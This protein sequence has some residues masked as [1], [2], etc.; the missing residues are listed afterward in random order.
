MKSIKR[1]T[2]VLSALVIGMC[3]LA[4]SPVI[5]KAEPLPSV[6]IYA[7]TTNSYDVQA[8]TVVVDRESNY[9]AYVGSDLIKEG[10]IP[11][12]G[13]YLEF[14][15]SST[16]RLEVYT[17]YD[18]NDDGVMDT[19]KP[20][21]GYSAR[22]YYLTVS[23]VEDDGSVLFS[24]QLLMDANNYPEYVYNAPA[25]VDAGS[26]VYTTSQSSVLIQYGSDD[27]TI[28][29][30][31]GSREA[32]HFSITYV[33]ENDNVIY[34]ETDPEETTLEY[35]QVKHID[36][37]ETF[38][39]NGQEYQLISTVRSY[40]VTYDNA[41]SAYVFEYAPV[42]AAPE[43]PYEITI[44]LVDADNNNALLYSIRQTV[45][46]G[47]SVRVELPNTYEVNFKQYVLEDGV[48]N[49]IERDF[50]STAPVK[51]DIP[52]RVA[53]ESVPYD[54]SINFIDYNNQDSILTTVSG[55]VT[56]DGAPFVYDLS[57]NNTYTDE[58]GT[59]YQLMAGQGNENGQI[60]HTYGSATRVYNIYYT[61]Q[62]VAD[63]QPY[64]VTMRYISV[65]DNSVLE[66][67]EQEVEY[68]SSVE[69]EAAP[70]NLTIDGTEYTRL[71]GQEDGV[72]HDYNVN[73]TDYAVYYIE[74]DAL[75]AEEVEPEVVTQVVTQYVTEEG[76][77]VENED[78]TAVPE[79]V[80]VT[81]VTGGDDEGTAYNEAGQE[82][83][84][85]EGNIEVVEP[86]EEVEAIPDEETPLG[87]Q[88]LEEDADTETADSEA[89]DNLE[90]IEDEETPLANQD[91]EESSAISPI[92]IVVII[93]A[94]AVVAVLVVISVKRKAN[95]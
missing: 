76:T 93:A 81:V 28:P 23:G 57:S 39:Y 52:Y 13:G 85:N 78:G 59:E 24:E 25:T 9:E 86:E 38:N 63:P 61:A 83:E 73:R 10:T 90:A 77:V 72:S 8:F 4:A 32:R 45:D 80:P 22:S 51:Y 42:I 43:E 17:P 67:Q 49:Y 19:Y 62:E 30:T 84:I 56:P 33:D 3:T 71:N 50:D 35:G 16:V 44:N 11:A 94:A 82:V 5:A 31:S 46:V 26:T 88:D 64:A 60:V 2:A 89:S 15:T 48:E 95:K 69:F 7:E 91:L 29:Y 12:G 54:I 37:D 92:V 47:G 34:T 40:D 6:S 65:S 21:I 55:T 27:V 75:E 1:I 14:S 79:A 53:E 36:A 66:T 87:N 58:N 18:I 68:G 41:A 74:S 20:T 70:E